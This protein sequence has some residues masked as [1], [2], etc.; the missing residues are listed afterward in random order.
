MP[1]I[2]LYFALALI[3]MIGVIFAVPDDKTI[4]P[5]QSPMDVMRELKQ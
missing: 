4:P 1:T 5:P 2:L 3:V